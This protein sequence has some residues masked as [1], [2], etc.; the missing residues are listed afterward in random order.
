ML[1]RSR[2]IVDGTNNLPAD[3]LLIG[4]KLAQDLGLSVGQ[5]VRLTSDRGHARTLRIGG[6]FTLGIASADRQAV[7]MN[8]STARALFDLPSGISRIEIK[9]EPAI[10]A[11]GVA[12]Q[13][14]G[15]TG[16]K[17]T[18]WTEENTQLFEGLDAQGRTGTIIKI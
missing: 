13:L 18:S 17:A 5:V 7:Y 9:V 8:F 15:A 2:A 1:F 10:A 11:A 14:H 12:A 6:I 16:L 3:G 4:R